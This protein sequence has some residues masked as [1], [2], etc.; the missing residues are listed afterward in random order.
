MAYIALVLFI[1]IIGV[2]AYTYAIYPL[3]LFILGLFRRKKRAADENYLPS[4]A[5]IISAYN[6]EK[7]IAE[8]LRNCLELDYP[9]EKLK[10]VVVSDGSV[11]STD[12]I[13]RSFTSDQIVL[14]SFNKREG[15]SAALNRAV[16]GLTEEILV[17]SDANAFY[18]KDAIRKLARNFAD[19]KTGCTVGRL[20]YLTNHSYVGRGE[21]L[22][23]RY[24]SLLNRL[25]SGLGS[26]LV[27]TGTIF[28]IRRELFSPIISCV[29]NDFQL[30]AAVAAQGYDVIYEP[31][32]VAYEKPTYYFKEEF[33]RKKR[34]I[35][36][37]LTGFKYLRTDFGGRLRLFQFVSRKLLRWWIGPLLPVLYVSNLFLLDYPLFM[38]V[39]VLQNL[40]YGLAAAGAILRRGRVQSRFLFIPFYFVLVNSASVAAIFT[41]LLGGR[42]SSWEKAETTRL[43]SEEESKIPKLEVIDGAKS[44]SFTRSQKK[45]DTLEKIT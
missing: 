37:G 7:V 27:G 29:A 15:K 1:S 4:V 33:K 43:L 26:V 38:S 32:A 3:I 35:I 12:D 8:K 17:F 11:D 18:E 19:E 44:T 14:K 13:V 34:I 30:P 20:I 23:W 2:A 22:Y 36:R 21:S 31:E 40:F 6:E 10:I 42:L 5:L 39:F 25:E 16:V 28:A 45:V 41:Y 24:E 9:S